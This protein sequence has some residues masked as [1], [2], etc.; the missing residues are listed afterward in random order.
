MAMALVAN[1]KRLVSVQP[2]FGAAK[3]ALMFHVKQR[4]VLD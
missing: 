3:E 4:D 1:G 2:P